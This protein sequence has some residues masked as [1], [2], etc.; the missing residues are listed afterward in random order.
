[1]QIDPVAVVFLLAANG[2]LVIGQFDLHVIPGKTGNGEADAQSRF[3]Q[4][5]DIVGGITVASG[6]VGPVEQL[7]EMIKSQQQRRIE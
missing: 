1:M 5:L 6:F 2:E 7:L 3:A 4:T